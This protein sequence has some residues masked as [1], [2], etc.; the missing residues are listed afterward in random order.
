[1]RQLG[2]Q[3]AE[4]LYRLFQGALAISHQYTLTHKSRTTACIAIRAFSSFGAVQV[5]DFTA[6]V[7]AN[8]NFAVAAAASTGHFFKTRLAQWTVLADVQTVFR[9]PGPAR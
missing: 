6:C 9:P 3:L 1:M 2:Q 8:P 5:V 7:A 4:F